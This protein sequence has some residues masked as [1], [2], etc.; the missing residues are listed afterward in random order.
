MAP[1]VL[2]EWRWDDAR[3]RISYP[4]SVRRAFRFA[5]VGLVAVGGCALPDPPGS[6]YRTSADVIASDGLMVDVALE[7]AVLDVTVDTPTFD[8]SPSLLVQRSCADTRTPGCGMV[9]LP[10][11]SFTQGSDDNCF[12][13]GNRDTCVTYGSPQQPG[14]R[15]SAFAM[16]AY[17]VTLGRF[18]AFM[19]ERATGS[20]RPSLIRSQPV[21]YRNNN[22]IVWGAAA[23]VPS[24]R[25]SWC[26]WDMSDTSIAAHPINCLDWW[27]SLEFCVW[28]GGRLPT[29]A[30]WEYAARGAAIGNLDA[31]RV[32]PWGSEQ[33]AASP[34]DRDR[35]Q[36][37]RAQWNRCPG[38]DGRRTRRVGSFA[39]TGG[40]FDLAG[41]V[42][43][44]TADNNEWYPTCRVST[45][46]PLCINRTTGDRVIRGGSWINDDRAALHGASR[47]GIG[48]S[49]AYTYHYDIGFRCAR[50]LP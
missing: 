23:H 9:P 20:A 31:G 40:F 2:L 3:C 11:G 14:I 32:Y 4:P 26:N 47:D 42:Y 15:V 44:W 29:E 19:R 5:Q 18:R 30:E 41:N 27:L 13:G 36:W 12:A 24:L 6:R 49:P 33:P 45:T 34:C 48:R 22:P 37:N 38:D 39:A 35:E 25:D 7:A 43:E 16:D 21:A 10:A 28:D 8:V 50:D 17:E 46:N 1:V